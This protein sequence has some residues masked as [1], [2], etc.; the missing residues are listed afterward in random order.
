[1]TVII[2]EKQYFASKNK[3]NKIFIVSASFNFYHTSLNSLSTALTFSIFLS[4]QSFSEELKIFTWEDYI[5]DTLIEEFEE[6][7]GHTVSQVYFENKV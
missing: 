2:L 6:Q 7:Y 1:M 5:S 3:F 4:T